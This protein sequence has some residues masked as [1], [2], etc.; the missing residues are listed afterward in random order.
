MKQSIKEVAEDLIPPILLRAL[1]N[2]GG[3]RIRFSDRYTTW[4]DAMAAAAGYDQP[5]ILEKVGQAALKVKRGEAVYERDAVLFDRIE[6]SWPLLAGLMW[7]GANVRK[8]LRILDFGGSL[9]TVYFQ[10]R[11][12]LDGVCARW[13]IVEQRTFVAMGR[14]HFEDDRLRF[15]ETID[16]AV[17]E[18]PPDVVILSGVLQFLREPYRMIERL[19]SISPALLI[20][21]R[22]PFSEQ[23]MDRIGVQHVPPQ[24]YQASYASHIFSLKKFE[25]WARAAGWEIMERFES[26]ADGAMVTESGLRFGFMGMLLRR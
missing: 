19:A 26:S 20:V 21:D 2:V 4:D 13:S 18:C 10:N 7:A 22:T 5:S 15:F 25:D 16:D 14:E 24:I 6:Y 9:G 11:K 1:R 8:P 12:F 23:P 17:A 3:Q